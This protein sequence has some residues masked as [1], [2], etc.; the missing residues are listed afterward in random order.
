MSQLLPFALRLA[1]VRRR[2]DE[3]AAWRVRAR[4]PIGGWAFDGA[5]IAVG[6]AWP[7]TDGVR[8]LTA[9]RFEVPGGWP[10]AETRLALDVGGESLLTIAHDSGRRLSLGLDLNH[11]EFVLDEPGGALEVEAVAKGPFGQAVREPRLTRAELIWTEPDV[12]A[13]TRT[14]RLTADLAAEIEGHELADELLELAETTMARLVWPT[15]TLD[16]VGRESGYGRWYGGRDALDP[17]VQM[18]PLPETAR[19][20]AREAAARFTIELKAL[21]ARFPPQGAVAYVGHAH[22]DTAWLWPIE[23]T[24]RKVK[25][26]FSTAADLIRRHP[27][28][29]YAQSFAEYYRGLEDDDPALL[30]EVKRL[31]AEGR[32][33]PVGGLW[34]EPDIN[35]PSGESL[36][37]QALYGQ[38]HFGATF[39]ARHTVAWLPDTFGFSPALPQILA[40]DTFK[41]ITSRGG[42]KR[43]WRRGNLPLAATAWG[44]PFPA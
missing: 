4:A 44:S 13:L 5:P 35:M 18:T 26:T 40:G 33:E 30:A 34:V 17:G 8:R 22:L 20:S 37:R 43:G 9:E 39:G 21:Q 25:R 11:T 6:S 23:E 28:F 2:I 24:R 31:A 14:L 12:G 15:R 10:L 36:V 3:I 42:S 16:V 41:R 29:R 27:G 32:W 19:A 38:R 7:A 1:R